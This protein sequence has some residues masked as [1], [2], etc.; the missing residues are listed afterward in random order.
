VPAL[1]SGR[2]IR[3]ALDINVLVADILSAARGRRNT[4]ASFLVQAVRTGTSPAGPV[5]LVTSLPIIENYANVLSRRLGYDAAAADE[6]AWILQQYAIEGP[7]PDHPYLSVGSGY[8]PFETEDEWR[9]SLANHL[10]RVEADKLFH[11]I[12]D[13][14]YVLETAMA[15]RADILVTADVTGFAKGPAVRF[16]R[17]DLLLFP[18]ADRALVIAA[19]RFVVYWLWQGVIPDAGFIADNPKDFVRRV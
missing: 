2:A 12:Q 1:T 3:L 6:K 4:A 10:G 11:E 7:A 8:I 9:R 5:Q 19:P 13:D 14:R 18:F 17:S 16:E 15:G